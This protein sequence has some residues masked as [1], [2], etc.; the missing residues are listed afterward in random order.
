M[1]Y[2][3]PKEIYAEDI[4]NIRKSLSMSQR[5]F[6]DFVGVS[7]PTVERWETAGK[8]ING[9]MA[10]LV[11]MLRRETDYEKKIRVPRKELPI[12][13]W[14]YHDR[15]VCTIIDVDE[16]RQR[17]EIHNYTENLLFR[18]FGPA[19]KP[20]FEEY[21]AFLESR[22]FPRERD[23][24]KIILRSLDIPFYDPFLIIEKTG[25]RTEEDDFHIVIER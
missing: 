3:T 23:K 8:A 4:K 9:P 12:R 1:Q 13:L 2:V 16:I 18:A 14:Y 20:T 19:E 7:K 11:D 22:C 10:M 5:E 25:G 17:V 15:M 24:Q 6:A 21:Q